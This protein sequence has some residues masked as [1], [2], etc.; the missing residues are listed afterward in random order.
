MKNEKLELFLLRIVVGGDV[1]GVV[2]VVGGDDGRAFLALADAH[3]VDAELENLVG[4]GADAAASREEFLAAAVEGVEGIVEV[5]A[6]AV[7]FV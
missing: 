3:V 7:V 6:H 1:E 2:Y 4:G 5:L